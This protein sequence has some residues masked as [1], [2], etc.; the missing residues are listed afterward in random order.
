ML[1]DRQL[2]ADLLGSNRDKA[3]AEL[4]RRYGAMVKR[5]AWRIT[6]DEHAAEDVCQAVF[7]VLIRK[8]GGLTRGNMLGPWLYRVAA[9]AARDVVKSQAR[10]HRREQESAMVAQAQDK[11]T[12]TLLKGL[13]EAINQLSEADRQV[14]V[15]HY[16]QGQSYAEVG[17]KLGLSEQTVQKRG[18]RSVNRL[19]QYLARA[20]APALSVAALTSLLSAEASAA[21]L[22]TAQ[23]AAIHA[24]INGSATAQAAALAN[25]AIKAM[26]WAKMKLVGAAVAVAVA[27]AVPAAVMLKPSDNGLVGHYAFAEGN[28]ASVKD[29]STS[30][31]HGT[32]IGNVTWVE[33]RKPGTKALSFDGK[34]GYVKVGQDLNQ[35]LGGSATVAFWISTRQVGKKVPFQFVPVTGV[36][37][38]S[39]DVKPNSDDINW[40][41]LDDSGRIGICPGDPAYPGAKKLEDIMA[42]SSQ[43]INDGQWHHV[44]LAR[45]AATGRLQVYVDGKLSAASETAAK[46]GKTTPFFYIGRQ[47]LFPVSSPKPVL[48]FQGQLSELRFYDRVLSAGEIEV[49]AR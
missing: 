31:N 4:I 26:F 42:V 32:L 23:V 40:G 24:A 16:F 20:G 49:L 15:A 6:G 8:A 34:T 27:V 17:A 1:D 37:V 33:G 25:L 48:Y 14:I 41:I 36:D 29:A 10:R 43:P 18:V 38:T 28:G 30:G 44:A 21:P 46:G 47:E 13:D 45:D 5:T 9:L 19:R 39:N 3:L 12:T 7:M 22:A 11:P 35:W 2:V